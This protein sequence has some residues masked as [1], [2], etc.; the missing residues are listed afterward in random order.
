[1][2]SSAAAVKTRAENR[3]DVQPLVLIV[4]YVGLGHPAFALKDVTDGAAG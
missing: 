1:M 2:E 3:K 4:R